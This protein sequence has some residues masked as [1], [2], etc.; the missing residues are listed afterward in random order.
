MFPSVRW[1]VYAEKRR[2]TGLRNVM[3][4]FGRSRM[5]WTASMTGFPP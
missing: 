1:K 4:I 5:A 3:M 2:S